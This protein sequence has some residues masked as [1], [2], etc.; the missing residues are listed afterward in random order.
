MK[1]HRGVRADHHQL[2]AL[3]RG[4]ASRCTKGAWAGARGVRMYRHRA[5]K[6]EA[7]AERAATPLQDFVGRFVESLYLGAASAAARR[8]LP[9]DPVETRNAARRAATPARWTE[10]PGSR[11]GFVNT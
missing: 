6:I 9:R 10:R 2:W 7:G 8:R 5:R 3:S 4:R 11:A 1:V